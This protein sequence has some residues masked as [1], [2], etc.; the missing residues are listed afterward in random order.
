MPSSW[1]DAQDESGQVLALLAVEAADGSS[2]MKTCGSIARRARSR[3]F[4]HAERQAVDGVVTVAL[5]LDEIQDLLDVA[6]VRELLV[7]RSAEEHRIG[8]NIGAHPRMAR[9]QEVVK[10]AHVCK[11]RRAGR[12]AP[13]QA[14]RWRA[15]SCG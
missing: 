13:R 2:S 14:R 15:A 5:E 7:L 1:L 8:D 11:E 12:C 9:D 10:D 4:L 6:P 3:R